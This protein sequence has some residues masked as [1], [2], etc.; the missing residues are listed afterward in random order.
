MVVCVE[1]KHLSLVLHR[2]PSMNEMRACIVSK[3]VFFIGSF[4]IRIIH[5]IQVSLFH[6]N[7]RGQF[8]VTYTHTKI[9]QDMAPPLRKTFQM[10]T[11]SL[12]HLSLSLPFSPSLSLNICQ[13]VFLIFSFLYSKQLIFIFSPSFFSFSVE[14]CY[15]TCYIFMS[16]YVMLIYLSVCLSLYYLL[17]L[18]LSF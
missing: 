10:I 8:R 3:W 7:Q 13:Y 14:T 16:N 15:V 6:W 1:W 9:G 4:F 17:Y 12:S 5:C 2:M 18:C 11:F